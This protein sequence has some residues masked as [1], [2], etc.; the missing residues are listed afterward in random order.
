MYMYSQNVS[1]ATIVDHG[2]LQHL[3][4]SPNSFI[5]LDSGIS[6][7]PATSQPVIGAGMT[8]PINSPTARNSREDGNCVGLGNGA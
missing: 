8:A 3:S 4:K 7:R 5:G 6:Q 1:S 2:E